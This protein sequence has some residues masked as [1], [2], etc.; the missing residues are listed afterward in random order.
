MDG[1]GAGTRVHV[2][3]RE[4]VPRQKL[5]IW[6][7]LLRES[8]WPRVARGIS[9]CP[10]GRPGLVGPEERDSLQ[11]GSGLGA[12]A[13]IHGVNGGPSYPQTWCCCWTN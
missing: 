4:R 10:A 11:R 3:V 5:E 6:R 9:K 12:D 1:R 13:K 7:G 2:A 8:V